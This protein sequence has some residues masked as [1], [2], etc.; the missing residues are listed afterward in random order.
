ME[1]G[2]IV[3]LS[4]GLALQTRGLDATIF[5]MPGERVAASEGNADHIALEQQDPLASWSTVRSLPR[6]FSVR[7]RPANFPFGASR[8]RLPFGLLLLRSVHRRRALS[9]R[10]NM[11]LLPWTST[12]SIT[13]A[14]SAAATLA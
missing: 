9:I 4:M 5:D 6:R 1:G 13:I 10:L 14:Q 7:S 12:S 2:G 8:R 3:G 11:S